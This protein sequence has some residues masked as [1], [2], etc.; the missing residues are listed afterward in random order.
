MQG[1]HQ[2]LPLLAGEHSK[3]GCEHLLDLCPCAGV[4]PRPLALQLV[5][6]RLMH[7]GRPPSRGH[8]LKNP[9]SLGN[10]RID[11]RRQRL[12]RVDPLHER[13][14]Y[15]AIAPD[16][17]EQERLTVG[18]L[19]P[20]SPQRYARA[21]GDSGHRRAQITLGVQG[22]HCVEDGAASAVRACSASVRRL[23]VD[24]IELGLVGWRTLDVHHIIL[25]WV[26][27]L[28]AVSPG[29]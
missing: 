5:G 24:G 6:E 7:P 8:F 1:A 23:D 22:T 12:V 28:D 2:L 19:L 29:S 9:S 16:R 15:F 13:S 14:L 4:P 27:R 25:W 21:R 3:L 10:E 17:L 11:P 18:K 26:G 20:D